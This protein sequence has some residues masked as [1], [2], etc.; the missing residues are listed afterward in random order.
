M[1]DAGGHPGFGNTCLRVPL[2]WCFT[3]TSWPGTRSGHA[4]LTADTLAMPALVM[5][6]GRLPADTQASGDIGPPDLQADCVVDQ[7]RQLG[8]QL[9]PLQPR[10]ADPLHPDLVALL[11]EHLKKYP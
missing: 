10:P 8:V 6:T 1:R 9:V 7:K 4:I 5:L 11:R 3:P 2:S